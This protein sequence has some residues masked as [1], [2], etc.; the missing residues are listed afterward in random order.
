MLRD[1]I[2]ERAHV[3]WRQGVACDGRHWYFS[4]RQYLMKYSLDLRLLVDNPSPIPL[5]LKS[6]GYEHIG[7]VDYDGGTL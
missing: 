1:L 3:L 6:I 5:E 7:D 2:K 4:S